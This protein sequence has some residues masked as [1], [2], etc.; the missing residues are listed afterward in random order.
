[1]ADEEKLSLVDHIDK[2]AN[3]YANPPADHDI[4]SGLANT[5]KCDGVLDR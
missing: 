1:M 4:G 3:N 2:G 5:F